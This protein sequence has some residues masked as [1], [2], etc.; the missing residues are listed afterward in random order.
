MA[1]AEE[2]PVQAGI[3]DRAELLAK[4]MIVP[5]IAYIV[6][7]IG[8]PFLMAIFYSVSDATTGDPT[9]RI[10]G[11]Q[12]YAAI[13]S[14]PVFRLALKNTFFF[15]FVSQ[16]LVIVFSRILAASLMQE[17]R[18]KWLAR[19]L[20][21][22]PWTAPI[23]L[24]TIGWLWILDSIFS[25]IDWILRNAGLLGTPGALLGP[26]TNMYWLGRSGLA[27]ASVIFVHVWR[28]LPLATVIQLA[29]LSSIPRD[30]LE[31]AEIDGAAG[32]RR[33]VE[34]TIPLTLPIIGIAFLFGLIFTF[35]DMAVVY[36]LTRGGPV[37]STQVLST[38]T[39][40]KGIQGGDLAQGAAIS[41]FLFPVLAGVATL[42][43]RLAR[44]TEVV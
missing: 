36:V 24:G 19:F 44:R 33:A 4:L 31:S 5:A 41:L 14:D 42:M 21:M 18:G 7:M 30:L 37:H 25:P 38:W 15:A 3:R 8:F 9:L 2:R 39:F 27:M 35:T 16:A 20:V 10:I 11:F 43:L 34:I 6:A 28:L 13:L 29:G 1:T 22:L 32:W 40:F 12:N 17:F 23:A 26:E